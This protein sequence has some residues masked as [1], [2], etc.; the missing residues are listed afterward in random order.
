MEVNLAPSWHKLYSTLIVLD[1]KCLSQ[2][3]FHERPCSLHEKV[4]N[5]QG[6]YSCRLLHGRKI[7]VIEEL[8]HVIVTGVMFHLSQS[9][10]QVGPP[11]LYARKSYEKLRRASSPRN[12]MLNPALEILCLC[13][14]VIIT[15]IYSQCVITKYLDASSIAVTQL[16]LKQFNC[17]WVLTQELTTSEEVTSLAV[18]FMTLDTVENKERE[19]LISEKTS[20]VIME[21]VPTPLFW[22]VVVSS[23][24]VI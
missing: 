24:D 2:H 13:P 17:R 19:H 7:I 8:C 20:I 1:A 5:E 21:E 16:L 23:L 22:A 14:P 18:I 4:I 12:M 6:V 3:I 9:T 11:V 15:P 10:P